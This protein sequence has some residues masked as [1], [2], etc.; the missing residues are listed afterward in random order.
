MRARAFSQQV[1][2]VPS[3]A[4]VAVALVGC[5]R[6]FSSKDAVWMRDADTPKALP[7]HDISLASDEPFLASLF[8][9]GRRRQGTG[10]LR[11]LPSAF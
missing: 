11:C 5:R 8:S 7:A 1:V 9:L 3:K 10:L 2:A 6:R 4:A